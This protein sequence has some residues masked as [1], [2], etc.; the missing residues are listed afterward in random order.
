MA[1]FR[2]ATASR[3]SVARGLTTRSPPR[4]DARGRPR[5]AM[6]YF[7]AL[8]VT[9][10]VFPVLSSAACSSKQEPEN[11]T[12]NTVSA[13]A[14]VK[15]TAEKDG[16]LL[17]LG[18]R[19]GTPITLSAEA[20]YTVKRKLGVVTKELKLEVDNAAPGTTYP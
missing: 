6:S 10:I 13:P 5:F 1:A 12:G 3:S 14:A 8:T 2:T 20:S 4:D 18:G 19:F 17:E 7:L 9:C 16:P 15:P 11:K